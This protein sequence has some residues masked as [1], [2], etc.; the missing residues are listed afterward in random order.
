MTAAAVM[1]VLLALLVV[2]GAWA[3]V[4]VM[5]G[6]EDAFFAGYEA[7]IRDARGESPRPR[8]VRSRALRRKVP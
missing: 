4:T 5:R 1:Y 8:N 6:Y 7:G 3:F 2:L